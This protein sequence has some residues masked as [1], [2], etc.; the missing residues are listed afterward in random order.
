MLAVLAAFAVSLAAPQ[1]TGPQAAPS[2]ATSQQ[3][4]V[5]PPVTTTGVRPEAED[6]NRMICRRGTTVVG[7]NRPRRVCAPAWEWEQA[8]QDT[9]EALRRDT[10]GPNTGGNIQ[11]GGGPP[12]RAF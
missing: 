11:V 4:T 6:P 9:R 10:Y 1:D 2:A 12:G 8:R 7:S 5:L 3:T